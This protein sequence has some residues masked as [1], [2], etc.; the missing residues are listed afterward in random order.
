M[1]TKGSWPSLLLVFS[2][3]L[4]FEKSPCSLSSTD[5]SM[6]TA[7]FTFSSSL[8]S[9][10]KLVISYCLV[11]GS[12]ITVAFIFVKDFRLGLGRATDIL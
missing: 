7:W 4:N 1:G 6:L 3:A 8:K 5:Y 2:P 11:A 12:S 10:S 9:I